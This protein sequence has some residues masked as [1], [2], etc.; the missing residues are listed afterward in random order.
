MLLPGQYQADDLLSNNA[1]NVDKAYL[2]GVWRYAVS[3][4]KAF[5]ECFTDDVI[6]EDNALDLLFKLPQDYPPN[7]GTFVFNHWLTCCFVG[8]RILQRVFFR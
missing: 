6:N 7:H 2:E 1:Y 8:S 4:G 5:R 3:M